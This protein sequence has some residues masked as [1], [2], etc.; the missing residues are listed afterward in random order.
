MTAP[1]KRFVDLILDADIIA[2]A[3]VFF[4]MGDVNDTPTKHRFSEEMGNYIRP[5]RARFFS[6]IIREFILTYV[7]DGTLYER[8]FANFQALEEWETAHRNQ[9]VLENGRYPCRSPGC[10]SSFKHVASTK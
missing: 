5:V 3:M 6:K 8:H 10:N 4:G 7:V 2:A 1:C 9:P